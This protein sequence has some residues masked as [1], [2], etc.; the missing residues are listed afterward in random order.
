LLTG[1]LASFFLGLLLFF[2]GLPLLGLGD[3]D[4]LG[5]PGPL[6]PGVLA[7]VFFLA[8]P[9]PFSNLRISAAQ[10]QF[11]TSSQVVSLYPFHL[12]KY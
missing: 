8:L 4:A 10:W 11:S 12:I 1:V 2:A 3:A 9:L 5:R 6:L 7:G